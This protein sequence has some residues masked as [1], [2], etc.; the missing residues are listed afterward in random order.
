MEAAP[1]K[2]LFTSTR[3][4]DTL[5]HKLPSS[6]VAYFPSN[7]AYTTSKKPFKPKV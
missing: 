3:L 7:I 2:R 1:P 5:S 6:A 4:H